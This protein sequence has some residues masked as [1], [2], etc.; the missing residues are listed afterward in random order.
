VVRTVVASLC[1]GRPAEALDLLATAQEYRPEAAVLRA[2]AGLAHDRSGAIERAVEAF[3]A[4]LY[5]DAGLF[6]A[7]LALADCLDRLGL[8]ERAGRERQRALTT[9]AGRGARQLPGAADLGL[10]GPD[11]ALRSC[12]GEGVK[13]TRA[14]SEGK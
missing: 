6:Q 13:A 14:R 10:P 5:L 12:G 7:R 2:L 11:E 1:A 9:L 8:A 3:R 4:A